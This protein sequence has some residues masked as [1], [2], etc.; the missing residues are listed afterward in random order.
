[1]SES[2]DPLRRGIRSYVIRAGRVTTAQQRAMAELWPRYGLDFSEQLLDF[3]EVFGRA[4]PLTIEIGFGNGAHLIE[5]ATAEPQR[6]FLGIE[7]HPPGVGALLLAANER[8]L[9]NLRIIRHHATAV[10]QCM[11]PGEA[12]EEIEILFPDPWP[13]VRHHKRRL[14]QPSFAELLATRLR[15]GGQLHLATDWEPYALHMLAVLQGCA[16]LENTAPPGGY[17]ISPRPRAATRFEQRGARLGHTTR[18][19]LWQRIAAA[20]Q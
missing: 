3:P 20:S 10:L 12:V 2:A 9:G 6:D 16:L 1:M 7:V 14:L 13:K 4:A 11:V 15:P 19:L 8:D 17:A 18:E 5:R